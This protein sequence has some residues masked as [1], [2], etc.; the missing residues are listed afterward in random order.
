MASVQKKIIFLFSLMFMLTLASCIELPA[1]QIGEDLEVF[2]ECNNCTYCNFTR[3]TY[4]GEAIFSN[5]EATQDDTHYY[6]NIA[7]GN[8]TEKGLITYCYKCGNSEESN[9]GCINV[10]LTYN[11]KEL[12]IQAA[13]VY[14]FMLLFLG[15][16]FFLLILAG[17]NLPKDIRDEEGYV[18]HPSNAAIL[19]PIMFG[20]GWIVLTAMM[21]I[22][23]NIA[24]A[25]LDTNILGEM[26]FL[27]FRFMMFATFLIIPLCVIM[28]IQK[29]VLKGELMK[30]IER[31]VPLT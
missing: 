11:G 29:I 26:I 1:K 27:I 7:A 25:Y 17:L 9:T 2:Q 20:L 5:V 10:P 24:I 16:V 30:L 12:T 31:G 6:F 13:I 8:I 22:T 15:A 21:Y 23:S 28:M 19:R 3:I 4:N 14:T 18:L